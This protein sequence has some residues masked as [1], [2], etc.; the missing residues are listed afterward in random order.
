MRNL[1]LQFVDERTIQHIEAMHSRQRTNPAPVRNWL[2]RVWQAI[3]ENLDGDGPRSIA[4]FERA[5][6]GPG[7][8]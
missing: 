1:P 2:G 7:R 4:N 8:R 6:K 3:L 5:M